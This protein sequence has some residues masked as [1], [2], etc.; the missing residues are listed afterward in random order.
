MKTFKA[1][2]TARGPGG[3]WTFLEIP[4]SVEKEF[5][6]K[7]RVAVAGTLNGF[8]FQN[9]LMPNGD[10][11]HS[12]M[13][14]KAL[15]AGARA[16]AGDLVT[17]AMDVDRSERVVDI[18]PELE[19]ALSTSKAAAAAFKTLSPSHRKEF[20]DWVATAKRDATRVSRAEKA[21]AMVIAKRH[22]R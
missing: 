5:G 20:A 10:G 13:V 15:Q 18:P 12:M 9:S 2:L 4:F 16:G 21:I 8:A 7:A 19:K 3:A 1:R 22:V 11:T 17:V 6:T 14:G